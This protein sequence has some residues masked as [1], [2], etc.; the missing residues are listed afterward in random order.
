[1]SVLH[2]SQKV[3]SQSPES[4]APMTTVANRAVRATETMEGNSAT[5][6]SSKGWQHFHILHG[7]PQASNLHSHWELQ[8]QYT[9]A[10][11]R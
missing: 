5:A 2:L 6:L 3:Y 10:Q 8:Y 9:A 11:G 1:M 7:P 4:E